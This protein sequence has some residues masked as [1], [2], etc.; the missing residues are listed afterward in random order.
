MTEIMPDS[1]IIRTATTSDLDSLI[2]LSTMVGSGMT[3]MPTDRQSWIDKVDRSIADFARE[4]PKRD[5]DIYF[6]VLEDISINKIV[7]CCAV[8]A[9]IGIQ[10]PFYSYKLST[11]TTSSERLDL[12]VYTRV[13]SLVNDFTGATE[14]GS[15]FLLPEYRRDGIGMFYRAVDFYCLLTFPSV[16]MKQFLQSCEGGWTKMMNLRSG[17]ILAENSLI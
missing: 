6:M 10:R 9:G 8:Y 14:I 5:G 11:I 17:I 7:G 1:L 12:T 13:L 16:S 15:L 4:T 2:E 3:S